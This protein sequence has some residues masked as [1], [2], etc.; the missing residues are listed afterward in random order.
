MVGLLRGLR[1]GGVLT[2][3]RQRCPGTRC[4]RAEFFDTDDFDTDGV[5]RPVDAC[6]DSGVNARVNTSTGRRPRTAPMRP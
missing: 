3:G 5:P 6:L 4:T 2:R 1:P